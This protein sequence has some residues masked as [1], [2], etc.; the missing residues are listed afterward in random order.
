MCIRDRPDV[1]LYANIKCK[2]I[3]VCTTFELMR[4]GTYNF[5][6]QPLSETIQK[7]IKLGRELERIETQQ[8]R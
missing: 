7:N 1:N 2:Y 4:S 3:C 8:L 6:N 5:R